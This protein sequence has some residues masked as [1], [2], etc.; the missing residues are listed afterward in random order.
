[1]GKEKIK[2]T[3]LGIIPLLVVMFILSRLVSTVV[4]CIILFAIVLGG[5]FLLSYRFISKRQVESYVAFI[6]P[7]NEQYA[8]ISSYYERVLGMVRKSKKEPLL[9]F[10]L[11]LLVA[12]VVFGWRAMFG[13]YPEFLK[14]LCATFGVFS[15]IEY[16]GKHNYSMEN[17]IEELKA[18][19]FGVA[20]VEFFDTACVRDFRYNRDYYYVFVRYSEKTMKLFIPLNVYSHVKSKQS[21]VGYLIKN[22]RGRGVFGRYDFIPEHFYGD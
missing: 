18:S 21:G 5:V 4:Y 15:L 16:V 22:S 20:R 6:E 3:L 17:A 7:S 8:M 9:M 11:F 2:S 19:D 13:L 10:P 14:T 12:L 1:M